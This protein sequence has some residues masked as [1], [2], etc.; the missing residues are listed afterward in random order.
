MVLWSWNGRFKCTVYLLQHIHGICS[1]FLQ[2]KNYDEK[3][4]NT[5]FIIMMAVVVVAAGVSVVAVAV[6]VA[7]AMAVVVMM[8]CTLTSFPIKCKF[9]LFSPSLACI[10]KLSLYCK[11]YLQSLRLSKVH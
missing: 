4:E 6:A 5:K 1:T 3:N 2:T 8:I 11:W 9:L 10:I 7:V